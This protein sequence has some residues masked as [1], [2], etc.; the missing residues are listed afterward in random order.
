MKLLVCGPRDWSNRRYVSDTLDDYFRSSRQ[1][2]GDWE[3]ITGG[4]KGVDT[5]AAE[6]ARDH[7][8]RCEVF[9]ANWHLHG[10]AAGPIRNQR[11]L[12]Q[13]KPDFVAAFGYDDRDELTP[14][15]RNMVNLAKRAGVMTN[16]FRGPR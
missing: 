15:T 1:S 14:G 6:W 4:A 2:V 11:M 9:C 3:I 12:D 10:K 16:I 7:N 8:I 13:G 5:M